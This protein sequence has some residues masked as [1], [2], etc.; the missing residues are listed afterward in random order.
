MRKLSVKTRI[1]VWLTLLMGLLAAL[2]LAFLLSISKVVAVRTAMSQL[3]QTVRSNLSHTAMPNGRLELG[4]GFDF[5]QNGVTTFT[6]EEAFQNGLTRTVSPGA[7]Q[8][9]VLDL[10]LPMGWENGVWLRGV[11]EAPENRRL[12]FKLLLVALIIMPAFMAL[13]AL[14]SYQRGPG[15]VAPHWTAAGKR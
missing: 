3:A 7:E 6:V 11:M 15:P 14:G 5:Y 10:W 9:L 13:A 1:A 8:Y 12:M 2:L 4:S